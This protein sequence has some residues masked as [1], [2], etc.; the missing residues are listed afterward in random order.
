MKPRSGALVWASK[1]E[2]PGPNPGGG[3]QEGS[4]GVKTFRLG[5]RADKHMFLRTEERFRV[6]IWAK[7]LARLMNVTCRLSE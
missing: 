2:N 6:P 1:R 3:E 5:V 4:E 7:P